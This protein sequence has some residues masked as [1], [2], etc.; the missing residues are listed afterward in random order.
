MPKSQSQD[1]IKVASLGESPKK[2]LM[3]VRETY[4]LPSERKDI[5]SKIGEILQKGKVQKIVLSVGNP[6]HVDRFVDGLDAGPQPE[7]VPYEDLWLEVRNSTLLDYVSIPSMSSIEN[8]SKAWDM[9]TDQNCRAEVIFTP[10]NFN[11]KDWLGFSI[12]DS[13]FGASVEVHKEMPEG[14][15]LLVGVNSDITIGIRVPIDIPMK[16]KNERHSK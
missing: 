6:I 3:L 9:I 12:K 1:S 11:S 8:L 10:R 14:A 4:P 15:V 16:G 13:L 7:E 2:N 5:V